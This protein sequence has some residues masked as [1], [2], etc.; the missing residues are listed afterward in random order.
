MNKNLNNID[1]LKKLAFTDLL[2]TCY[3]RNWLKYCYCPEKDNSNHY[4]FIDIKDLRGINNNSGYLH[5]DITLKNAGIYLKKFGKVVRLGGD[6]FLVICKNE[7]IYLKALS[8][9]YKKFHITGV[10]SCK[11]ITRIIEK[12][13]KKLKK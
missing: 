10:K 8:Y 12:L 13:D 6:E 4:L 3:N 9:K 11:P 2:T 1:F 5:G 7:E